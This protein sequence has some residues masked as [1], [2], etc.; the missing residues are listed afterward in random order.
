MYFFFFFGFVNVGSG[1]NRISFFPVF[2]TLPYSFPG[3][4]VIPGKTIRLE[5]IILKTSFNSTTE[6]PK[7]RI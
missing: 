1:E 5:E 4:A 7:R 2:K 3:K 6:F